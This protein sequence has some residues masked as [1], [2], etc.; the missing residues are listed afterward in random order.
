MSRFI[1]SPFWD[2]WFASKDVSRSLI[3][4]SPYLK[5]T[6]LD[7]IIDLYKLD[8]PECVLDVKILIRG[9]LED[10][11]KGSSDLTALQALLNL[12]CINVDKVRRVTNLHMKAYLIDNEDLLIGSGNCTSRGLAPCGILGNIEGGV[13]TE[14]E[15]IIEDFKEHFN[16]LFEAAESLN[17]FY[18]SITEQ[19]T[20]E[21]IAI[22]R[23]GP[24]VSKSHS[25]SEG[26]AIFDYRVTKEKVLEIPDV[27][28]GITIEDVPQFSNFNV[29]INDTL[30][31]LKAANIEG[32]LLTFSEL[33]GRLPGQE[34]DN[35]AARKK[36]GENHSKAAQILGFVTVIPGKTR[37]LKLSPL[38]ETYLSA[39][40]D[41][42]DRILTR[43]LMRTA[44][45]KSILIGYDRCGQ[46]DVKS[47]LERFMAEST[48]ERR[49]PCVKALF[50]KLVELDVEGASDV[51]E[52][53]FNE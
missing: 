21:A 43:Q 10:F 7:N 32:K 51:I 39:S 23:E 42:K 11:L 3:I 19:Y 49:R 36:Y 48:A 45:V 5:K 18:D 37:R 33:G 14:D 24:T 30:R 29:V 40:K 53:L 50:Q 20:K 25:S 15:T 12:R 44:I 26:N 1:K 41:E 28:I 13:Q 16:E 46:F 34:S 52:N 31:V 38:G 6:A 2:N 27:D 22:F 35:D 9:Q 47:Y 17:D 4:C 8:E